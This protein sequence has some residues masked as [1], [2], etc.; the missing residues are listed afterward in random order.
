MSKRSSVL[1]L[2]FFFPHERAN[3]LRCRAIVIVLHIVGYNVDCEGR[4]IL[5][6]MAS[7]QDLPAPFLIDQGICETHSA[8]LVRPDGC[9]A[10]VAVH[11]VVQKFLFRV[12]ESPIKL[13]RTYSDISLRNSSALLS[14][15]VRAN[16]SRTR[17]AFY[18]RAWTSTGLP[19]RGVTTQSPTFRRDRIDYDTDARRQLFTGNSSP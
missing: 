16:S 1:L 17:N 3:F 19:V 4:S 14:P 6:H 9:I 13:T 2:S 18:L 11:Y 10:S 8:Y 7:R 15:A 12:P 5:W